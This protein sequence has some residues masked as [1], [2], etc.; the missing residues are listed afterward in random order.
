MGMKAV[1]KMLFQ[2]SADTSNEVLRVIVSHL[3]QRL[4]LVTVNAQ[5][6]CCIDPAQVMNFG[7][8]AAYA[9]SPQN[10]CQRNEVECNLHM[11]CKWYRVEVDE[12][13]TEKKMVQCPKVSRVEGVNY[14]PETENPSFPAKSGCAP[15]TFL[16]EDGSPQQV[17]REPKSEIKCYYQVFMYTFDSREQ[18][19]RNCQVDDSDILV[20]EPKQEPP[21][22]ESDSCASLECMR[23]ALKAF[24][25]ICPH[26]DTVCEA[27]PTIRSYPMRDRL[28]VSCFRDNQMVETQDTELREKTLSEEEKRW[29]PSFCAKI[30]GKLGDSCSPWS[31]FRRDEDVEMLHC[32]DKARDLTSGSV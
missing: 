29:V 17:Y 13:S 27:T 11:G 3:N 4:G 31:F 8:R 18:S 32:I 7:V 14:I 16:K 2:K 22:D 30:Q 19:G 9:R 23:A 24:K 25:A 21:C 1:I 6:L 28:E 10:C 26:S 15:L 20:F 5:G 12:T